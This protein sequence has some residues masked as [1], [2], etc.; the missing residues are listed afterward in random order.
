MTATKVTPMIQQYLEIKDQYREYIL[1]YRMG[2]FYEMFFDDAEVA[3]REL[4]ITLTARNKHDDVSVPMCGV[5]AKAAEGYIGRL[6]EK[7][8]KVAICDQT[9][10]PA[11]AKGLVKRDVVRVVTP[12]MVVNSDLL[13]EKANNFV[14]A[15]FLGEKGHGIAS[16]DI[17]TGTFRL[18]ESGSGN[19]VLEEALR[20]GPSEIVMPE[21]AR[22]D[23]RY[24]EMLAAFENT[25]ATFLEDRVFDLQEARQRLL[26]QFKTRNLEGFGCESAT[27]GLSAA[28]ALLYYL[29]DTQKQDISHLDRLETYHLDRY[30]FVDAISSRNLELAKN[31]R[32]GA[33]QGTLLSV[34][35]KTVTAMGGRLLRHWLNYPLQD[36]GAITTR[37]DAVA[38]AREQITLRKSLR[39]HLQSVGDLQRLSGKIAMGQA[40]ARDLL[41][42]KRSI[43]M[44][45]E[46]TEDLEQMRADLYHWDAALYAP[47]MD[48]A[49]L[50][51][52]AIEPDPPPTLH[53][54]GIIRRGYNSDLDELIHISTEGKSFLSELAERER[55]RT[56]IQSLKVSYNKVFGYYIEISR[57]RSEAVPADY[58]RKQTLVNAERFITEEL[59]EFESKVLGAQEKRQQLEY[60]LFTNIRAQVV[61]SHAEIA[62]AARFIARLD[63][64]LNL[65]EIADRNHYVRPEINTDSVIDIKEGR[66]PVVE[67]L[68]AAERFVPNSVSMTPDESQVMIITGPNMAGKS[69]VLRQV[70]LIVLMAHMGAFV[71][72]E[73]ANISLTDRIFTRVGALDNLSQGQST[74]LVEMQETANIINNASPN[75]LVVMDEIGRG[76]ST[77]DGLSIAWAVAEHLH[78]LRGRGVKTLFATHYHELTELAGIK[79]RMKNFSIA[80]KEWNDEI[81]FLHKLVTGA[82]NR[83]YGIQVARLAGIP[84]KIVHRSKKILSN[85]ENTGYPL[86]KASPESEQAPDSG[87]GPVQLSLFRPPEQ[88]IL[89]KLRAIDVS[90]ITPLDA[91]NYLHMLKETANH[92]AGD[93]SERSRKSGD[94]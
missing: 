82:A 2:D 74:F 7:G 3:S 57:A 24:E 13:E 86:G 38:E 4:E 52:A 5:P 18:A 63:C 73:S 47:L 30:L 51:E 76:T 77:Y 66:H 6:I 56:G 40:N 62:A 90:S 92:S 34:L 39:S 84:D 70:A 79:P 48:V 12:G 81:I 35:D 93:P 14:V 87:G 29:H 17:S 19:T 32:T 49:D 25:A 65:A 41:G 26:T 72:A 88:V 33:R 10:D 45:P 22:S 28:G 36:T 15:L 68:I 43:Q 9:E 42:L 23:S 46:I 75:S 27:V 16:L 78:D 44:I 60:E 71:P 67:K 69:T 31:I 80:V 11:Q 54:G 50:I 1:F 37:L 53:E 8:Y 83:S 85:V 58:I 55:A 91:I 61:E 94:Q 89:D 21:A 20:V 59:K 64:L